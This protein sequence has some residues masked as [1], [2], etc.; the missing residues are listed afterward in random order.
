MR[1]LGQ[2]R[3]QYDC[4]KQTKTQTDTKGRPREGS[5]S[6]Q[7][8]TSQGEGPQRRPTPLTPWPQAFSFQTS[9]KINVCYLS[10]PLCGTLLRQ[11]YRTNPRSR[12]PRAVILSKRMGPDLG[13]GQMTGK[14]RKDCGFYPQAWEMTAACRRR[15]YIA[16][17][18]DQSHLVPVW[19]EPANLAVQS[20]RRQEP[21]LKTQRAPILH[22]CKRRAWVILSVQPTNSEPRLEDLRT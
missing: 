13:L 14:W 17:E 10:H 15:H 20:G 9:E 8:L 18:D 4:N 22:V 6:R 21:R 5:A 19:K 11:P 1:S 16:K 12:N 7:P 3:I 2:A